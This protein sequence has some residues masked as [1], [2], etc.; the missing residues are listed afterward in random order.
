MQKLF[1]D[2]H[3]FAEDIKKRAELKDNSNERRRHLRR[4]EPPKKLKEYIQNPES[5][6]EPEESSIGR[7]PTPK[8]K[9]V[10]IPA[11]DDVINQ[12][13]VKPA[14]D[15]RVHY[16]PSMVL[17][18]DFDVANLKSVVV[19]IDIDEVD[20]KAKMVNDAGEGQGE[21]EGEDVGEGEQEKMSDAGEGVKAKKKKLVL[22]KKKKKKA[23]KASE[24][25]E[26]VEELPSSPTRLTS[27]HIQPE[28]R[29]VFPE[30]R[31]PRDTPDRPE[32]KSHEKSPDAQPVEPLV[33]RVRT[34]SHP[35]F[36]TDKFM[37]R[38]RADTEQVR[39]PR[40]IM[41]DHR[42]S[43]SSPEKKRHRRPVS[44]HVDY[45]RQP[46]SPDTD[47]ERLPTSPKKQK[48][49]KAN[50][51]KE[52][53]SP[54]GK[55]KR[56]VF[57]AKRKDKE[58][59]KEVVE[60]D[61]WVIVDDKGMLELFYLTSVSSLNIFYFLDSLCRSEVVKHHVMP[62]SKIQVRRETFTWKKLHFFS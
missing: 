47:E 30:K 15:G 53:L 8:L 40:P 19:D 29:P 12:L 52:A 31:A 38:M 9:R 51:P 35:I 11:D 20:D 56:K 13:A 57:K 17:S 46:I 60:N 44:A 34:E 28:V 59:E 2:D 42:P 14:E 10:S 21:G 41:P 18:D 26:E 39:L 27:P 49:R 32:T 61:D 1:E 43:L 58:K 45:I 16:P 50:K 62:W 5:P 6:D 54:N 25:I 33:P 36:P 23:D 7:P 24:T 4:L 22:K 55:K 37:P 48:D 3:L